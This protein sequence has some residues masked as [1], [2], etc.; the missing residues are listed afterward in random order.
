M[1]IP[2][3][4]NFNSAPPHTFG[5]LIEVLGGFGSS[6]QVLSESDECRR[7]IFRPYPIRDIF[8]RT[9]LPLLPVLVELIVHELGLSVLTMGN[10]LMIW[11]NIRLATE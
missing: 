1:T 6:R 11:T 10:T 5:L 3:S 7:Q 2:L 4:S 8:W 9:I